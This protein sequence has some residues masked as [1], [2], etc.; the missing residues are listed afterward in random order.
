MLTFCVEATYFGI[1][2]DIYR[3][4]EGLTMSSSSLPVLANI[5]MRY[6]EEGSISLKP[7]LWLRFVDDTFV[8]WPRQEDVQIQ[9]D[10]VNSIRSFI[11]FTMEIEQDNRLSFLDQQITCTE[12]EIRST[13]YRK[14]AFTEQYLNFNSY[15]PYNEKTGIIRC[16]QH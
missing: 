15:H 6:L 3:H 8:L 12:Q 2:S 7:S 16:L 13:V 9:L 10:H 4:E 14:P 11:Q 5:I 1:G